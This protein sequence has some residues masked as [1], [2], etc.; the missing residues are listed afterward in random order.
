MQ[1]DEIDRTSL[2][3]PYVTMT[4]MPAMHCHVNKATDCCLKG[5]Q[6]IYCDYNKNT[7]IST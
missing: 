6:M 3:S 7:C 5:Q 1:Q 2:M 4:D